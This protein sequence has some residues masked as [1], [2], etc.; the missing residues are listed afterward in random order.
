MY[1]CV[2]VS[3]CVCMCVGKQIVRAL[4]DYVS[5]ETDPSADAPDLNF[6]KGD[7]MEVISKSVPLSSFFI[8]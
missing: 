1:V 5:A 2:C 7:V 4:Y 8:L 6:K 3:M